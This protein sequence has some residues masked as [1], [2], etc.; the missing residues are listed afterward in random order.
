[1][2]DYADFLDGSYSLNNFFKSGVSRSP[3]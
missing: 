1:M 3:L 2:I